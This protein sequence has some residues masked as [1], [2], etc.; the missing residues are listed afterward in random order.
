MLGKKSTKLIE[1]TKPLLFPWRN[2]F[3]FIQVNNK[4]AQ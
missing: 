3:M 2:D 4:L 1:Y